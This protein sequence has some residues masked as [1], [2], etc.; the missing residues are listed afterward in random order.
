MQHSTT[1]PI[2]QINYSCA[3]SAKPYLIRGDQARLQQI[4][5][6]LLQNAI[7][8]SPLGGPI[9]FSV[10]QQHTLHAPPS[11]EIVVADKGIG[12]PPEAQHHLFERFYRAPNIGSNQAG[13]IGLGLY[14]VAEFLRL[15]GGSIC[16]KSSGVAGDGS[17]F[18]VT[19]PM[20]EEDNAQNETS[21]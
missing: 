18:V 5:V 13:G 1:S 9:T 14:V 11:I 3:A 21:K 6:N 20:L 8:Y 10:R 16:V 15:H 4:F 19:L 2:H 12:V 17:S 7:K